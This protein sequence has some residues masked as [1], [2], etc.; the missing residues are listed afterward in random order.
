MGMK[1]FL[2]VLVFSVAAE[3]QTLTVK[4]FCSVKGAT[5]NMRAAIA[6]TW[7]GGGRTQIYDVTCTATGCSGAYVSASPK[8]RPDGLLLLS[9]SVDALGP[10]IDIQLK[11]NSKGVAVLVWG[12]Y[13]FTVDSVNGIISM[14]APASL[15]DDIETGA[16]RCT[17][18]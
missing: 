4:S 9:D 17:R 15:S 6:S 1:T 13:T 8:R 5:V 3:A 14:T 10:M 12:N 18:P 11:S 7:K 2:V 16:A